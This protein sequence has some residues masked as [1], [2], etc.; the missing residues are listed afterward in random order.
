MKVAFITGNKNRIDIAKKIFDKYGIELE[1][2]NIE[3][4]EIQSTS[5]KE[6]AEY[7]AEYGANLLNKAVIKADAGY[8]IEA[9]NGFPGPFVKYVC[10][11]FKTDDLLKM[12]SNYSDRTITIRETI[13]F[14]RP[15]EKAISFTGDVVGKIAFKAD[16]NGT[17]FD[18]LVILDGFDKVQGSLEREELLE[19]WDNNHGYYH[20]LAKYIKN[21]LKK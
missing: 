5:T 9:L 8:Y 15:G 20:D 19:Y 10:Q 6:I 13:A 16:A 12:M 7:S 4:P 3:T 21:N 11:W 2:E 17:I 18:Q 1:Q 14:C